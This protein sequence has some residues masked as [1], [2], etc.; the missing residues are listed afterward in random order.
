MAVGRFL[1]PSALTVYNDALRRGAGILKF[2][3]SVQIC[4][5]PATI[6]LSLTFN[7]G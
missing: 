5:H 2:Y 7:P 1:P 3:S 4:L 6:L